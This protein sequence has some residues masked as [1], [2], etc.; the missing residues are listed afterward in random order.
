M[1]VV[2]RVPFGTLPGYNRI[3]VDLIEDFQRVRDLFSWD[4]RR[5]DDWRK[6]L[7][8]RQAPRRGRLS[9][10][11]ADQNRALGASEATIEAALAISDNTTFV[12]TTGQQLSIFGGCLF[13]FYKTLTAMRLAAEL[14]GRLGVRVVPVFWMEGEDHD[15]AEVDHLSV[16]GPE[17]QTLHLEGTRQSREPVGDR[18]LPQEIDLLHGRLREALPSTEF[19]RDLLDRLASI[20][21]PGVSWAEAFGRWWTHLFPGL[22]LVN[23]SDPRIKELAAPVFRQEMERA[24]EIVESSARRDE[25]IEAMGYDLQVRTTYP[26]FFW[27]RS[28]ERQGVRFEGGRYFLAQS[29]ED[30][31]Q[32]MDRPYLFSP[33]VLLRPVVQ[34]FLMPNLAT[35]TG[36]GEIAYFAQAEALFA[37]HGMVPS[38]LYPR[39]AATILEKPVAKFMAGAGLSLPELAQG[40]RAIFERL[41]GAHPEDALFAASL[42]QI[43]AVAAALS[44]LAA[45]VDP[46]LTGAI[47]TAREKVVY[48]ISNLRSKFSRARYQKEETTSRR[49]EAAC[50][51]CFPGGVLQE[52][53]AAGVYFLAKYGPAFLAE[54]ADALPAACADHLVLTID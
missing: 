5:E 3:Y 41:K 30:I 17:V 39:A 11:L 45:E 12:V 1:R 42:D 26:N 48:Q 40:P 51:S 35:V 23:P 15:L 50:S 28:G 31:T 29:D 7:E 27:L 32:G 33:K 6:I 44:P 43:E 25:L 21:Q 52:R 20:Y 22:V 54:L 19:T 18:P 36:P 4:F 49:L 2:D 10:V 24:G 8:A 16:P 9:Q 46:T 14:S 47:D 34:D 37:A 53:V 13:Y 38:V